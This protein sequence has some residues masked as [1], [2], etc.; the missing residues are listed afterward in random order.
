[1]DRDWA[2]V[3]VRRNRGSS[4]EHSDWKYIHGR[5]WGS[6]LL[7]Y[8][9][10]SHFITYHF[11]IPQIIHSIIPIVWPHS[12]F[13]RLC[14]DP[15]NCVNPHSQVVSDQ[16]TLFLHSSTLNCSCTRISI[17]KP[18]TVWSRVM[19]GSVP[20]ISIVSPQ[21]ELECGFWFGK[22]SMKL[23]ER[24]LPANTGKYVQKQLLDDAYNVELEC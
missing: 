14:L 21:K 2:M 18:W 17:G 3:R 20:S 5:P 4:D 1:M 12:L 23:W 13:P 11:L 19:T 9:I 6:W 15:C 7:S 16:I 22:L 24:T 10:S 8:C